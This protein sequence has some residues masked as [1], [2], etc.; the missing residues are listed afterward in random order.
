VLLLLNRRGTSGSRLCRN[1]GQVAQCTR[2]SAPLVVHIR[3]SQTIGVC[4]TCGHQR[5]M[6]AHC[7]NCFHHDFLDIGSGTQRVSEVIAARWPT[8]TRHPMGSRHRR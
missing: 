5:Y 3:A 6:D 7:Q 8:P 2:C 4:H 1:C